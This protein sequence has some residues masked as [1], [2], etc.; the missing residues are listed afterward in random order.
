MRDTRD[1]GRGAAAEV[2]RTARR[3]AG[4]SQTRLAALAGTTQSAI[5]A[6]EAGS[7]EP[8]VPV[9]ARMLAAAGE[10]LEL[11]T[12]P[13]SGLYRLAD[14]ARDIAAADPADGERRLRLVLE[15]LRAAHDDGHPLALL[16]A[17]E[18]PP[19][20]DPRCDALLAAVAEDLCVAAGEPPPAWVH[21]PG[22]F[23]D[24]AW[25]VSDLPSA[26]AA[27]LVHAPASYRRRGVMVDRRDLVAA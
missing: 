16:V 15:F 21:E 5:A 1:P 8:T 24:R 20:G 17:A 9:L 3:R 19:T 18:P 25:W 7:R 10:R 23:L 14:A 11:A 27:A 22:R 2:L 6:Y 26:R 4:L 13:D 12:A